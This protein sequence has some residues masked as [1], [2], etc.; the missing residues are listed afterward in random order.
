MLV[1][2]QRL[3]PAVLLVSGALLASAPPAAATSCALDPSA[4]PEAIAAGSYRSAYGGPDFF[5]AYDVALVGTVTGKQVD[6]E[7]GPATVTFDV[8]GVLG[9]PQAPAVMDVTVKDDGQLNGYRYEV[10]QGYFVPL[11]DRGPDG[12]RNFSFLCDPIS[13]IADADR[14][15]T[16]LGAL[17]EGRGLAAAAPSTAADADADAE[18]GQDLAGTRPGWAGA[19]AGLLVLAAAGAVTAAVRRPQSAHGLCGRRTP[20][21]R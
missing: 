1:T 20:P 7:F 9:R 17:A 4:T 2:V 18:V 19:A 13:P 10:G 21:A 5:D 6:G 15:F 8:A 3:V 12:L 11:V 14:E 16:R